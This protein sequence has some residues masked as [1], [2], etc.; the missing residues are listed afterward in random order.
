MLGVGLILLPQMSNSVGIQQRIIGDLMALG[1]AALLATYVLW[2]GAIARKG[3]SL[4]P[5]NVVF[6]ACLLGCGLSTLCTAFLSNPTGSSGL[7]SQAAIVL[8]G[9][10]ILSTATSTL[11]YTIAAQRLPALLATA[12]LLTEPIF[13]VIFA[14]VALEEIPS[15]WFAI[16]SFFVLGG[17]LSIAKA[18][19]T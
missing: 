13:A 6:I 11:L 7:N 3:Q 15:W 5:I 12:L 4:K 19:E 9:L 18:T 8:L 2:F 1:S 17:L 16:G 14:S 10:G